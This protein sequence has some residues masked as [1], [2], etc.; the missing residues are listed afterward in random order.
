[1]KPILLSG[2]PETMM[3]GFGTV[4]VQERASAVVCDFHSTS[5]HEAISPICLFYDRRLF[6]ISIRLAPEARQP[7]AVAAVLARIQNVWQRFAYRTTTPWWIFGC[8]G[9]A[10]VVI[11]LLTVGIQALKAAYRNPVQALRAE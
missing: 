5:L 11:A 9:M 10:A 7:K 1:M 4:I 8:C 3:F 6:E 2:P